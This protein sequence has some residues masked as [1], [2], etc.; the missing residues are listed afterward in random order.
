MLKPSD[1]LRK[2]SPQKTLSAVEFL[3][4]LKD[5]TSYIERGLEIDPD[6]FRDS[7]TLSDWLEEIRDMV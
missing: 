7:Q 6:D 1:L 3:M 5:M 4:W 2:T